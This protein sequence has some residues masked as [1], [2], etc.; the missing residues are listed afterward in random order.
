MQYIKISLFGKPINKKNN[1]IYGKGHVFKKTEV[2]Q[3]ENLLQER[4]GHAKS[5][6]EEAHQC[7][8]RWDKKF[9]LKISITFGDKRKRDIHNY[10][11]VIAD[12]LEGILIE[13]DSQIYEVRANK[14][15]EPGMWKYVIELAEMR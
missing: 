2:V 10:F 15:I 8:W 9:R 5:L 7:Q 14:I 4:L 11:D 13:D 6:W 3:F 1:M 12:C